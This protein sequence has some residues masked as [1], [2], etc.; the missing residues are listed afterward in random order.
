MNDTITFCDLST[1]DI[2]AYVKSSMTFKEGQR[3]SIK[4]CAYL[5]RNVTFAVG[6]GGLC[7]IVHIE[8]V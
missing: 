8:K 6:S 3:V 2:L 7:C 1:G 4:S 5:V